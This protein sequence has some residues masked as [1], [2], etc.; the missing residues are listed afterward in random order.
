MTLT[1]LTRIEAPYVSNCSDNFPA[2]MD[3]S[4]FSSSHR[5]SMELCKQVCLATYVQ[6]KCNCSDPLLF[7]ARHQ[8]PELEGST[9]C[10]VVRSDPQRECAEKMMEKYNS[11]PDMK[12]T[13][14]CQEEC[15]TLHYKT[16]ISFNRW[17]SS[18]YWAM[19]AEKYGI[20]Y[21]NMTVSYVEATRSEVQGNDGPFLDNLREAVQN[22]FIKV[23]YMFLQAIS[24]CLWMKAELFLKGFPSYS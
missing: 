17:P 22:S 11:D 23:R 10:S 21:N 14:D 7:E 8:V 24:F 9:F 2:A 3:N 13:C 16:S 18:T 15:N 20:K 6:N 4:T 1:K 12:Y 5:Y 19:L